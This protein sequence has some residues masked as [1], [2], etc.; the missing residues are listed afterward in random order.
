MSGV[1]GIVLVAYKILQKDRPPKG[2]PKTETMILRVV[3]AGSYF[4]VNPKPKN[5]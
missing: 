1:D 5:P 3:C 2:P 4:R